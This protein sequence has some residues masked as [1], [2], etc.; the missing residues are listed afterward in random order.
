[1]RNF[2]SALLAAGICLLAGG[3]VFADSPEDLWSKPAH[4]FDGVK[5]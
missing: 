2:K 4:D 3:T 1:M 5:V